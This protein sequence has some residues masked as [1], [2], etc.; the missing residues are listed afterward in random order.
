MANDSRRLTIVNTRLDATRVF[1]LIDF[2]VWRRLFAYRIRIIVAHA[3]RAGDIITQPL[4][5]GML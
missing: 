3:W 2:F 1:Y 5:G 4:A